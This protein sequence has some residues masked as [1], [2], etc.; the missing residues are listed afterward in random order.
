[1]ES[2]ESYRERYGFG[3]PAIDAAVEKFLECG[4]PQHGFARVRC[5]ECACEFA[6]SEE[7]D[8]QVRRD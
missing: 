8:S 6:W 2:W 1:M 7:I 5:P 3:C 4:D